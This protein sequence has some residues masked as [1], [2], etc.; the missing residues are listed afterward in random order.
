MVKPVWQ[1]ICSP[2]VQSAVEVCAEAHRGTEESQYPCSGGYGVDC[3]C[4]EKMLLVAIHSMRYSDFQ[5]AYLI[6]LCSYFSLEEIKGK[7]NLPLQL[8]DVL[9][10]N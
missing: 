9:V 1:V 2:C 3:H 7:Y 8:V 4:S 6:T 5:N 10:S